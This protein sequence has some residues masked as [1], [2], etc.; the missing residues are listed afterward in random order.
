MT[1]RKKV[2][3]HMESNIKSVKEEIKCVELAGVL[4]LVSVL[5][6]KDMRR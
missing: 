6:Q 3:T 1:E 2:L 4:S 5:V